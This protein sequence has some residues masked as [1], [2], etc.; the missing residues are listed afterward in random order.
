[1][2]KSYFFP[3]LL[4]ITSLILSSVFILAFVVMPFLTVINHI[5]LLPLILKAGWPTLFKRGSGKLIPNIELYSMQMFLLV[6]TNATFLFSFNKWNDTRCSYT[7]Q[8][9]IKIPGIKYGSIWKEASLLKANNNENKPQNAQ[10]NSSS[11]HPSAAFII[12]GKS[13][14]A[15]STEATSLLVNSTP[16]NSTMT[17]PSQAKSAWGKFNGESGLQAPNWLFSPQPLPRS[18]T[19]TSYLNITN[20]N[21]WIIITLISPVL[22]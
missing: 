10:Y 9:N 15:Q 8:D 21:F 7:T 17:E 14:Q 22:P 11:Q 13:P 2:Q 3:S 4:F 19:W 20:N 18:I 5:Y 6:T 16:E 1:M 12:T